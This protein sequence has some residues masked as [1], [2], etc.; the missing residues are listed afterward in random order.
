MII[1]GS[2]YTWLT[3]ATL[4]CCAIAASGGA[5]PSRAGGGPLRVLGVM[6]TCIGL[7]ALAWAGYQV[8]AEYGFTYRPTH[9][10]VG[11]SLLV[12]LAGCA[13]LIFARRVRRLTRFAAVLLILSATV[14]VCGLYLGALAGA[15]QPEQSSV[16][17]L[18]KIFIIHSLYG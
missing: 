3:F 11:M 13:G 2:A 18:V 7:L 8:W 12:A 6:G 14:S 17:F 5:S 9:L 10:R 1:G 16:T 4:A 15:I